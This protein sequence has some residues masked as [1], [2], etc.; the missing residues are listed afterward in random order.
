MQAMGSSHSLPGAR[1]M[2]KRVG[3]RLEDAMS[4]AR[5]NQAVVSCTRG[6]LR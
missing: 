5:P 1:V 3:G 6:T 4:F 2:E